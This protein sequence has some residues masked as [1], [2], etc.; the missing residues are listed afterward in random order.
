MALANVAA[1]LTRRGRR[2]LIVDFDL[3]APGIPT[4]RHFSP[5][6]SGLGIVDY[7]NEYRR[8]S[9][10]PEIGGY[11][12]DCFI[13]TDDK[14]LPIWVI[15]A[16]KLDDDYSWNLSE[17]DW[18]DLYENRS[19]YLLFE[20]FKQQI[21][22]DPRDFDYVLVD[23]RTGH[24]DVGG[25]CTRQLADTV[26][27]MYFPNKQN[28]YGLETIV[29]N[30][31]QENIGRRDNINLLFCA[32]NV[33][34][35]DDENGILRQLLVMAQDRI[36]HEE[37]DVIINHY[38]SL[39]LVDQSLFVIDRPST[40]LA[41]QY[42]SLTDAV[43]QQNLEDA[44]GARSMLRSIGENLDYR[45]R[46]IAGRGDSRK[47]VSLNDMMALLDRVA[48]THSKNGG[49][50]WD[51]ANVYN[52]LGDLSGELEALTTAINSDYNSTK[53]LVRR[54]KNLLS[55]SRKEEAERDLRAVIAANDA[56]VVDISSAIES[57]KNIDENWAQI[58]ADSDAVKNIKPADLSV[59]ANV[60]MSDLEG[61]FSTWMKASCGIS[62]LPNW[63]M[64]F[65]ALFLLFE[66]L[67]LARDVAA[68]AFGGHVLAHGRDGLAGDDLAADGRL[69]RD[70]E[71]V[72]GD[73]VLQLLAHLPAALFGRG[74]VD[75]HGQRVD[76]LL[77]DEDLTS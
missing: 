19:G 10:A 48:S 70:L 45:G 27:I 14:Q 35:L 39:S 22:N 63:R 8:T 40:K 76:R 73:Q 11:I 16:G 59:L 74:A 13:H 57:L 33:P 5:A 52:S 41:R 28:I 53:A 71:H 9:T 44:E 61:T 2:V 66:E 75:Q 51:L 56:T 54:A 58:V 4:Y 67:A 68:V 20:D 3:E 62:T 60:L 26:V 46:H 12:S 29:N 1:E 15:P 31:R 24:T 43:I 49:I 17:I 7:V 30:V 37:P 55:Q 21:S 38:N 36:G 77:V 64:R 6:D 23:S 69:D 42:R 65:L 50:A 47:T 18:Q 34:D 72:A 25:I 32:S